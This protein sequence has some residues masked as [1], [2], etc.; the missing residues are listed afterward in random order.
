M[1][2][3]R[4]WTA[5]ATRQCSILRD[6]RSELRFTTPSQT[7]PDVGRICRILALPLSRMP[8]WID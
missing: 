1:S 8:Y 7:P 4:I 3:E 2:M 6:T 5:L